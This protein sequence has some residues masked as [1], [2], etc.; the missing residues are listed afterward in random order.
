MDDYALNDI[1]GQ[2]EAWLR[3]EEDGRRANLRGAYLRGANLQDADLQ[4]AYLRRADLRG[5]NL[6]F[7]SWPLWCG[8][9]DVIVD[10]R[11]AAQLAAHLCAVT[12]DDPAYLVAREALLPFA[13]SSHRVEDLGLM[14][15]Q[16]IAKAEGR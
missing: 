7:S 12:C 14:E 15:A 4:G 8:S 11:I 1:L 10:V 16:I 9:R 3:D 5:A 2:H 13:R 6:D